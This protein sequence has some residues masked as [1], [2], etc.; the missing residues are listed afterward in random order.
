MI[1]LT[2]T[3]IPTSLAPFFQEYNLEQ[4]NLE[5]SAATIIERILRFVNRTELNRL[6][7]CYPPAQI[8]DWVQKWGRYALPPAHMAFWSL[9]LDLPEGD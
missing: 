5:L 3:G 2:S 4:L 7:R 1:D 8:A 9:I 6:F